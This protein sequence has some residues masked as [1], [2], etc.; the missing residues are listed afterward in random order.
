M[1]MTHKVKAIIRDEHGNVTH[2]QEAS[3][4]I[5]NGDA[6]SSV[7][8]GYVM[9]LALLF[10]DDNGYFID[11][12]SALDEMELGTGTPSNS[13]LGTPVSPTTVE[14]ITKTWDVSSWSAPIVTASVTWD[15]SYGALSGIT[16]ATLANVDGDI[17][18]YKSF[19][20][21]LSKTAGGDLT[22]EWSITMS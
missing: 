22:I 19:T 16:E 12:T 6:S 2:E 1:K 20:P 21:A 18:A 10:N 13:G 4:T 11:P 15:S 8:N 9:A 14:S 5:S 3:N 17:F 7:D